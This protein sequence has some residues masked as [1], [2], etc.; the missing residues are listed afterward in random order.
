MK[1]SDISSMRST[2]LP[3]DLSSLPYSQ[4]YHHD[5]SEN[6]SELVAP[7]VMGSFEPSR[8]PSLPEAT[9]L[10]DRICGN[11]DDVYSPNDLIP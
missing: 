5:G 9:E 6:L 4:I 3:L 11:A 2:G 7:T 10:E 8:T 1:G